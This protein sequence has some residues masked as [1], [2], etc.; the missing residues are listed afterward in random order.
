MKS[1]EN[2]EEKT[3]KNKIPQSLK[4]IINKK[5]T[6]SMFNDA[7]AAK[8]R[9]WGKFFNVLGISLSTTVMIIQSATKFTGKKKFKLCEWSF[10]FWSSSMLCYELHQYMMKIVTKL[11][12]IVRISNNSW[13]LF[14]V[15]KILRNF[16]N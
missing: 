12:F 6:F 3:L 2:R 11:I 13:S 10:I 15:A 9:R 14:S 4:L 7:K 16:I 8:K 5:E 1:F